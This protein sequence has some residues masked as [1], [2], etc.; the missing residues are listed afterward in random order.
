MKYLVGINAVILEEM[1]DVMET[2]ENDR[3]KRR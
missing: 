3:S 2:E 1:V